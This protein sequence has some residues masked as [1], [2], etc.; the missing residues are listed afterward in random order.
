MLSITEIMRM[1]DFVVLRFTFRNLGDRPVLLFKGIFDPCGYADRQ[2]Q[3]WTHNCHS[4][5]DSTIRFDVV[6]P[7]L[8]SDFEPSYP[9]DC[10][11]VLLRP[12]E[13]EQCSLEVPLP[14]HPVVAYQP[15]VLSG[16]VRVSKRLELRVGY[17][18]PED[19]TRLGILEVSGYAY[20]YAATASRM[21]QQVAV[22]VIDN[23]N[24][25]AH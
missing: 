1:D 20:R 15:P 21:F 6:V 7:E 9:L 17:M 23:V 24:L 11:G 19:P 14:V 25:P 13:I 4:L 2:L 8:P 3:T 18:F 12:G 5:P 16:P 10:Y 22:A